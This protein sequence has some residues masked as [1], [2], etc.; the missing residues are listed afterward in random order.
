MR[1]RRF[2]LLAVMLSVM[3]C[4]APPD[5]ESFDLEITLNTPFNHDFT[6][7][8]TVRIGQPFELTATN[9]AVTN[10]VSGTL[11][12]PASGAYPLDLTVSEWASEK[13]NL[14]DTTKLT[15]ELG[16]TSGFG[17][18]SSFLYVRQ[19]TLR[20]HEPHLKPK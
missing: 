15:L 17:P 2:F 16:K 7:L 11:R 10:R 3:A 6:M 5:A 12:A 1:D 4:G 9:G 20:R 14:R 18:V 13:S 19:V 8:T